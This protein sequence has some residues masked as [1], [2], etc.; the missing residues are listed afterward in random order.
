ML[1]VVSRRASNMN[2]SF[3]LIG[4]SALVRS[5]TICSPDFSVNAGIWSQIVLLHT[6]MNIHMSF[7]LLISAFK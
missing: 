1:L 3:S 2:I 7:H 4:I 5:P 6:R